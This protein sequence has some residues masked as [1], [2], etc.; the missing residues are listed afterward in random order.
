MTKK[1]DWLIVGEI[2]SPQG[3]K[4]QL[5]VK[6]LSDF[7]ERFT[8]PGSRWIQKKEEEPTR[9]KL[10]SGFKKPG[11][12]I[13]I[14][15]LEGIN[16]RSQAESLSKQKILVKNN[17]IPKLKNGEFHINELLNLKVKLSSNNQMEIIGE[18]I[19]L[20]NESNNLLMINLFS[21]NKKILIPFVKE[22]VTSINKEEKY[23][24]IKPP[25]GLL[26]L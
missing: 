19:D 3:V 11:K 16:S 21:T 4:G 20:L 15:S 23:I 1:K 9:I 17:D 26:D 18:V 25:K 8:K 2:T 6:S 5:R 12:E 22:I 13:F 7:E 10:I 14:I 24:V